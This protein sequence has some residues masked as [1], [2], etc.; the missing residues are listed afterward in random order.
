MTKS[1][2][3]PEDIPEK[4][5]HNPIV[6]PPLTNPFR[7]LPTQQ[8]ASQASGDTSQEAKSKAPEQ[9]ENKN[10]EA[11]LPIAHAKIAPGVRIVAFGI[12]FLVCYLLAVLTTLMPFVNRLLELQTVMIIVFLARDFFFDGRGFG[13]NA[14]GLRVVD[15][16]SGQAPTLTQSVLRNII[17]V[18]WFVAFQ[19]VATALKFVSLG[20][21]GS[22]TLELVKFVCA[23]YVVVVVPIE[24]YRALFR[25]DLL[26]KGDELAHTKII[27]A[28]TDFSHFLPPPKA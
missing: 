7:Q 27:E 9:N 21:F 1:I 15:A 10:P 6:T 3:S 18:A 5:E 22:A 24:G 17:L 8:S 28:P 11:K 20:W 14:M 2:G 26:R 19:S 23:V 4:S 16:S 25:P 12:D 13:K